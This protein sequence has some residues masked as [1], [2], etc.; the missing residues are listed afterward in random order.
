MPNTRKD[1]PRYTLT[2]P[3]RVFDRHV[4]LLIATVTS[5]KDLVA[6]K[7]GVHRSYVWN[8][9]YRPAVR[10]YIDELIAQREQMVLEQSVALVIAQQQEEYEARKR[11]T[12]E[13][14]A[15]DRRRKA[16]RY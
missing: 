6:K 9:W 16:A 5:N 14:K 1:D 10:A 8:S 3:L 2:T 11:E 12:A 13:R 15:R 4:A 7:L